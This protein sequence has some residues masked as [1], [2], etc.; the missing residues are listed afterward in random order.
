MARVPHHPGPG[1]L[2]VSGM[3]VPDGPSDMRRYRL[4]LNRLRPELMVRVS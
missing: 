3:G 1:V 4:W 2:L